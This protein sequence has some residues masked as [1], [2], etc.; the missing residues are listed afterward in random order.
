MSRE[1]PSQRI[2]QCLEN[3]EGMASSDERLQVSDCMNN[4]V[5]M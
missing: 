3:T 4:I 5:F 2:A 1:P